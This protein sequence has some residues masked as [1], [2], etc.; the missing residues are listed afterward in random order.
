MSSVEEFL[1]WFA[2]LDGVFDAPPPFGDPVDLLAHGLQCA[3][4]LR[5]AYPDDLGLQ[6]AGLVHDV[7][8][9]V[10]GAGDH[11]SAGA[12]VVRPLLGARVAGLVALHVEAKRYLAATEDYEFSVASRLSLA[13]QGSA[14]TDDEAA[15][16]RAHPLAEA[17]IALRRADEEAKVVGREVP[18][19]DTWAPRLRRWS[20]APADQG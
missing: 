14:M 4:V 18:G 5:S 16:F 13:R 7:G 3:D 15:A 6:L 1:S 9:A 8:H 12:F 11:A 10:E 19:L 20:A 2:A 17:A